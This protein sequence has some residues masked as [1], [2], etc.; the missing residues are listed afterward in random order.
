MKTRLSALIA[1]VAMLL[2]VAAFGSEPV[3]SQIR[4][5]IAAGVTG[6]PGFPIFRELAQLISRNVPGVAATVEVTGGPPDIMRRIGAKRADLGYT[7]GIVARDALLGEGPFAGN[8]VPVRTLAP[9]WD[10]P[11]HLVTFEGSGINTIGDLRGKR[12]WV[13]VPGGPVERDVPRILKAVGMDYARDLRVE[14]LG[15]A[16]AFA[17]L[18]ERRIDALFWSDVEYLPAPLV[19]ELATT[20][21]LRIR[22]IPLDSVLPALQKEFGNRYLK[23]T[24]QKEYYPGMAADVP[25]VGTAFL[26]VSHQ[27]LSPNLAYEITKL[28]FERRGEL[29][30]AHRVAQFI[31]LIGAAGR[32]SIPFHLGAIRYFKE[33]GVEGF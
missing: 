9:L 7:G 32:S 2:M 5:T 8:P 10:I 13:D 12:V 14:R 21:G 15:V 23:M 31:T 4:V 6:W 18:R 27:D 25:T 28:T 29:V 17:A 30:R 20:P 19:M 1:V 11:Y 3:T 33:R 24:I 16:E 22:L 26:L